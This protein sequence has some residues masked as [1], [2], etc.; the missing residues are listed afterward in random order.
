MANKRAQISKPKAT[1][2][3]VSLRPDRIQWVRQ[4]ADRRGIS[5]SQVV[6]DLIDEARK[7]TERESMTA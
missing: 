5:I 2:L 4:T 6:R 1:M 7:Q 3:G